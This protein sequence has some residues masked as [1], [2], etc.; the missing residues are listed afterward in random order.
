MS[1]ESRNDIR[2][3]FDEVR[4][5]VV[6]KNKQYGDSVLDPVRIFSKAPI[7]EQIKVRLDDKLSRLARGD[8]SME[9]DDDIFR[10]IMGYC[11]LAIISIER[12]K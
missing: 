9:S 7:H 3:V 5:M 4:D 1:K 11:A 2:R 8:D 12:N 6:A 10:D